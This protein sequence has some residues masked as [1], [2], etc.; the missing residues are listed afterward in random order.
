MTNN[1]SRKDNDY[2]D[3]GLTKLLNGMGTSDI[4]GIRAKSFQDR[5]VGGRK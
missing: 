2:G 4:L 5:I 3:I 1:E